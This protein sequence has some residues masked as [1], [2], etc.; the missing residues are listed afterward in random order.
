MTGIR[1][2]AAMVLAAGTGMRM[3]PITNNIPK[4]LI[5]V[6]GKA[7]IDHG[8]DALSKAA[9]SKAVVNVHHFPEQMESHLNDRASPRV[10]ISNE[11]DTLLDSGGG[12]A[13]ALP[14]LGTKPF[15]LLNADSFWLEGANPNL[16]LL[17]EGWRDDEMDILLL[18]SSLSNCVGYDGKGDFT[19]DPEGRLNRRCE[20]EIAPFAYCGAAILHPRI[21]KTVPDGAF[22]L[23]LLF[24]RAIEENRLFG[25]RM[26][27][28]WLH[29]GTPAAINEAEMAIAKS[30]A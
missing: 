2:T 4:P 21:F 10:T 16:Q 12:V 7:L 25:I 8:L 19:M 20:R 3:R 18:L 24:D 27:G 15:Y 14:E 26:G 30:A 29:V 17:C 23:N 22:S 11:R 28:L 9:V 5:R 6:F 13:K 1:P